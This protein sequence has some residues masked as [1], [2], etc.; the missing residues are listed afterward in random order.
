MPAQAG[1][2]PQESDD[3]AIANVRALLDVQIRSQAR[4]SGGH[5]IH[6]QQ[7]SGS[8]TVHNGDIYNFG[9]YKGAIANRD[10]NLT[11]IISSP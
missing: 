5:H 10:R 4:V 2:C 3:C 8:A 7:V 6:D 1:D 11:E 9:M